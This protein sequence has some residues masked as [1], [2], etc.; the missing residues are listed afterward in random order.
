VTGSPSVNF[1]PGLIV[2]VHTV[3]VALGFTELACT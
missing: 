2:I 1:Q 3:A